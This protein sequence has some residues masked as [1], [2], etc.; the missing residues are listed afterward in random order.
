[1]TLLLELSEN[2]IIC[3]CNAFKFIQYINRKQKL[4]SFYTFFK[5]ELHKLKCQKP[6][7]LFDRYLTN[8]RVTE[9]FC[10]I[11]KDANLNDQ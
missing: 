10:N 1:M 9:L 8:L 3:D 5:I 11:E 4:N 6:N 2:T 7:H